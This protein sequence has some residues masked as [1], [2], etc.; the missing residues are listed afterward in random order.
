VG[1][2]KRYSAMPSQRR[3]MGVA[4]RVRWY[5]GRMLRWV[6]Q[7]TMARKKR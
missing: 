3:K 6:Q 1:E 4:A 7:S 5:C 2:R